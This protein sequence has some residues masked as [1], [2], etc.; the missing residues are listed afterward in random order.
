MLA[1]AERPG[2]AR[3]SDRDSELPALGDLGSRPLT[4]SSPWCRVYQAGV[5]PPWL[6]AHW[7]CTGPWHLE[8]HLARLLKV[9]GRLDS[10]LICWW[11]CQTEAPQGEPQPPT[12]D[13]R[14]LQ[15][16]GY[17]AH[18]PSHFCSPDCALSSL[19]Q[20]LPIPALPDVG[21][22]PCLTQSLQN[23]TYPRSPPPT[24]SRPHRLGP[25]QP[26]P[27]A[28]PTTTPGIEVPAAPEQA[29]KRGEGTVRSGLLTALRV[30]RKKVSF[31][32]EDQCF[33][34]ILVFDGSVGSCL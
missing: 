14:P 27:A 19:N 12:P 2:T 3:Q 22:L 32:M 31:G 1:C 5:P 21:P 8:S 30:Q 16:L 26:G 29:A 28:V 33:L 9:L 23:E 13:C 34:F 4:V 6:D 18:C 24:T 17:F 7:E 20:D 25:A 10:A 15:P 11:A